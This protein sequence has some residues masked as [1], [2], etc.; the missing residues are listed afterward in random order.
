[1]TIP[2]HQLRAIEELRRN[3]QTSAEALALL[4]KLH[5]KRRDSQYVTYWEP[6]AQQ[7]VAI[8]RFTGDKKVFGV[9]GG[10]RSGKTEL[11][12]F[13]AVAW[14]L[15]KKF[16][17]DEPAWEHVKDLPIPEKPNIIWIVGLD[18]SVVQN[19]IW[20]EKLRQGRNHPAFLP[21]DPD[22]VKV[23]DG[24]FQVHFAN[25]SAIYCKSADSGREKFQ[26]ASVDLVWIDEECEVD[27]FDECFQRTVDCSGK[28]LVTLTPLTDISSGVRTPW[29]FDLYEAHKRGQTD[30]EFV[31]LSVLDNPFVP[32]E[33]K[34]RLLAKWT[35]HPEE[36]ARLYGE[37][38]RRA[39]LV[40]NMW[41][42]ARHMVKPFRIPDGWRRIVSI[43]PAATGVTAV[44]WA[45][46]DGASNVILYREYYEKGEVVSEHAKS[47]LVRNAGDPV[48]IWLIDPK[49]GTQ[50]NAET[51]KS[52]SQLYREAGIPV[53]LAPVGEDFG[54]N[55]S[56]E[57]VNATVT[58]GS[59]HPKLYVFNDLDKF[60]W[61]IEHYV[62]GM[63]QRGEMKG[64]SKERP[65]KRDD[66]LCNAFQYL[67]TLRPKSKA[68]GA[69][70]LSDEQMRH[71]AFLNSYTTPM[72]GPLSIVETVSE[73][74][75]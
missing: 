17:E 21:K 16:F 33:E 64:L 26:G 49:W 41:D 63:F 53:R 57:Y 28:L 54:L 71:E 30:L 68:G 6:T 15:G 29:V 73:W 2:N 22:L 43:D 38:I 24:D 50:R 32:E 52:N 72:P 39:G 27:V 34:T 67:C 69:G 7:A 35:G 65:M 66:H 42:P 5:E 9:I 10:N 1:V 56:L 25:G 61:E 74:P 60:R 3:S 11:G 23:R 13:I 8:K 36:R 48:D 37:F 18:F 44:L 47:I 51:H 12:T 55:A 20:R 46:I 4:D 19:V 40:Y 45:A 62:W 75:R 31:Q 59:R 70:T 58:P 14:A